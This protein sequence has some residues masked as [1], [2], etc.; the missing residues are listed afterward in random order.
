MITA[1]VMLFIFIQSALPGDTSGAESGWIVCVVSRLIAA[2]TS[3]SPDSM[4]V[5]F[6]VRKMAHFTEFAILGACLMQN[7][8]DWWSEKAV[9]LR[10]LRDRSPD[11]DPVHELKARQLWSLA[12]ILSIAYAITDELH[13]IFV[14]G[15]SCQIRDVCIDAAGAGLGALVLYV[16]RTRKSLNKTK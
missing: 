13:Q 3:R 9:E 8:M 10:K 14:D 16:C 12:W 2:V 15:R 4:T 6:A 7:T 11:G 5:D 1:A